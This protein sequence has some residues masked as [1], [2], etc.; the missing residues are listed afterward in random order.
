MIKIVV[1]NQKGGV[2]KTATSSALAAG[3]AIRGARVLAVDM[4]PSGDFTRGCGLADTPDGIYAVMIQEGPVKDYV[5]MGSAGFE[6]L[7]SCP[8][9]STLEGELAGRIGRE[10]R[11]KEALDE[12]EKQN[13]YDFVVIDTPPSY[14]V[15]TVNA[16]TA[17]DY[18]VIPILGDFNSIEG[19][20]LLWDVIKGVSRYCNPSLKILG[21]LLT[22]FNEQFNIN[23]AI[24]TLASSIAQQ[25]GTTVF[26]VYIR[27]SVVVPGAI[28]NCKSIF[29]YAPDSTV[30]QDY[31]AFVDLVVEDIKQDILS[32]EVKA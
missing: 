16:L 26:P 24:G 31:S 27:K 7:A 5:Q 25:I 15:L 6:V 20:K 11:L 10:F 32:K 23:K 9:L 19:A 12:V 3:L 28:T 21:M 29:E 2:A 17:A 22:Q 30:A 4:D 18:V 14:G 8:V 1:A 13:L